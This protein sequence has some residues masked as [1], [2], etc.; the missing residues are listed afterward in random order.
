MRDRS[1]VNLRQSP[2]RLPPFPSSR[3]GFASLLRRKFFD[4]SIRTANLCLKKTGLKLAVQILRRYPCTSTDRKMRLLVLDLLTGLHRETGKASKERP[5]EGPYPER[6]EGGIGNTS[7]LLPH[8]GISAYA[9]A[10]VR[11]S[12]ARHSSG[13]KKSMSANSFSRVLETPDP[14]AKRVSL[15]TAGKSIPPCKSHGPRNSCWHSLMQLVN[16]EF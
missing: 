4:E 7:S 5:D 12:L 9:G 16:S 11:D 8:P 15:R 13:R 10:T 1:V 3:N 2:F 6:N 14:R